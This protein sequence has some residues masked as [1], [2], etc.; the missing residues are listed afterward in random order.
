MSHQLRLTAEKIAQRLALV[1]PLVARARLP[2][3]RFSFE[4]LADA[5]VKPDLTQGQALRD[6]L[7]GQTQLVG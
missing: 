6:F 5:T 2:I 1:R 3:E 7:G 4:E